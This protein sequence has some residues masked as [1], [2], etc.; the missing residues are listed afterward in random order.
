MLNEVLDKCA[1]KIDGPSGNDLWAL[2]SAQ[3]ALNRGIS[4]ELVLETLLDALFKSHRKFHEL[5]VEMIMY[6]S[7]TVEDLALLKKMGKL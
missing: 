1:K 3:A 6:K 7:T 4:E 2:Y 5:Q